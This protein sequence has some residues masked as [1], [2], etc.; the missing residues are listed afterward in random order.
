MLV[1]IFVTIRLLLQRRL[2]IKI[3]GKEHAKHYVSIVSMLVESAAVTSVI[4]V[5][6]IVLFSLS[7]PVGNV[8]ASMLPQVTVCCCC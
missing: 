7:H 2:V 5:P 8:F 1:T 6:S 3:L 4:G